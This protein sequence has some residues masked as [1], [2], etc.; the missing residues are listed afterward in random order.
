MHYREYF[1][2]NQISHLSRSIL[3]QLVQI[4]HYRQREIITEIYHYIYPIRHENQKGFFIANVNLP[5]A[6]DK[7]YESPSS[8]SDS[9]IH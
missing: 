4:I 8:K 2:R 5:S 6:G 7:I 9:F 1:I 3:H